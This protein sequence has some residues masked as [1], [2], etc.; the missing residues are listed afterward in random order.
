MCRQLP[1][2]IKALMPSLKTLTV[3]EQSWNAY[4]VCRTG[5]NIDVKVVVN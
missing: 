3:D 5:M 4:P 2:W 1:G